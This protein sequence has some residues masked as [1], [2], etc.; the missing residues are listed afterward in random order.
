MR[1]LKL[2]LLSR[3]TGDQHC[4]IH[5]HVIRKIK[6]LLT[7]SA[8][9]R[10]FYGTLCRSRM[11]CWKVLS[12]NQSTIYR[13]E[14]LSENHGAVQK[15]MVAKGSASRVNRPHGDFRLPA[16]VRCHDIPLASRQ[17]WHSPPLQNFAPY[18]ISYLLIVLFLILYDILQF[19]LFVFF[20]LFFLCVIFIN[21]ELNILQILCIEML[22]YGTIIQMIPRT[23]STFL[24][25]LYY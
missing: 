8:I 18:W 15:H 23:D 21:V 20:I 1:Y 6:F 11:I 19:I 4:R 16:T 25:S 5:Y 7:F 10:G 24:L 14:V 9:L 2:R 13:L 17:V 3:D 12:Y 22:F